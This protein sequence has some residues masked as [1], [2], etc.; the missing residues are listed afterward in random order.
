[1]CEGRD[2]EACLRRYFLLAVLLPRLPLP[3]SLR[4]FAG[5]RPGLKLKPSFIITEQQLLP[6]GMGVELGRIP[7]GCKGLLSSPLHFD[8]PVRGLR[9]MK[10]TI[11]NH[12]YYSKCKLHVE[13]KHHLSH[14]DSVLALDEASCHVCAM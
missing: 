5:P 8:F 3:L 13:G 11:G 2:H 6:F 1:V 12:V 10:S 14:T 9:T 4:A 7:Q